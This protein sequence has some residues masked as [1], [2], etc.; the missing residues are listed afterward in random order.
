MGGDLRI[1]AN[2]EILDIGAYVDSAGITGVG[3]VDIKKNGISILSTKITI[4]SGEKTSKT[5]VTSPIISNS[6]IEDDAIITFDI[7][8]LQSTPAKGLVVW[9]KL[10]KA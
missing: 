10:M 7:T 9:I 5:A 4:D 1:P 2:M 3:T 6:Y 8:T